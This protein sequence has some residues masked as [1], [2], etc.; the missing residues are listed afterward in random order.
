MKLGHNGHLNTR[1]KFPKEFFPKSNDFHSNFGWTQ[2]ASFGG[3]EEKSKE[4]KELEPW[5]QSKVGGTL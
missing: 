2:K 3:N 5:I 4:S 1:N